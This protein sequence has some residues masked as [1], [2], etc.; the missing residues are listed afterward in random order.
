[1]IYIFITILH[2]RLFLVARRPV[3]IS[4]YGRPVVIS[5]YG[6]VMGDRGQLNQV[7][8]VVLTLVAIYSFLHEHP[9]GREAKHTRNMELSAA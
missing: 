7:D 4:Y 8:D 5:Y 2:S 3:V 9:L 6:S 1:M